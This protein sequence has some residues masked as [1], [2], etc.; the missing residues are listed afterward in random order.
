MSIPGVPPAVAALGLQN[1]RYSNFTRRGS[2]AFA[3]TIRILTDISTAASPRRA[4][5]RMVPTIR[6]AAVSRRRCMPPFTRS[7]A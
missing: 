4:R 6:P 7:S 1:T 2:C 5:P 3:A